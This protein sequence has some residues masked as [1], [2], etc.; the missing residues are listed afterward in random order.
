MKTKKAIDRSPLIPRNPERIDWNGRVK[1]ILGTN[2]KLE[3]TPAG[4]DVVN[5]G[6]SLAPAKRSGIINVC[7]HATK[8]CI[9]ACVLWFAGRTTSAAVR[10]AMIA[11]TMLWFFNPARFYA[12][13]IREI[14]NQEKRARK[15]GARSFARGNVASDTL[16]PRE[17][18]DS[19]PDTSWYDYT[20]DFQRMMAYL[21]GE[22]APNYSLSFSIHE[23]SKFSEVSEVI[24]AGGNIVVVV[25]SYYWGPSK[26]YGTLPEFVSI[27]DRN[28]GETINVNAVD[29]DV[30]DI[31]TPEFDGRYSA[32]CLRLK[33]QSNKVR[34]GA[35]RSGFAR[36]FEY[37]GK[38]HSIRYAMPP[39]RGTLTLLLD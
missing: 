33:G 13:L 11:R 12:R 2:K 1:S 29:G 8:A 17:L 6:V 21:R 14:H 9:L 30:S 36:P 34:E 35:R 32:V 25:D 20:K 27:V 3:K 38:E 4:H 24:R 31:R 23:Q 10:R 22:L 26:R 19:T 39:A 16:H 37:G 18:F 5:S 28:T 15:L 7:E